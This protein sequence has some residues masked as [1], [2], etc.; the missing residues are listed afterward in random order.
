MSRLYES[1]NC[2]Y[3]RQVIVANATSCRAS[4]IRGQP[5]DRRTQIAEASFA[6][7]DW[8]PVPAGA[9][10]SRQ[11]PGPTR[12]AR[13]KQTSVLTRCKRLGRRLPM[14]C[15]LLQTSQRWCQSLPTPTRPLD[16]S[17]PRQPAR[18]STSSA[19]KYRASPG[20]ACNPSAMS[21]RRRKIAATGIKY[22]TQPLRQ[23]ARTA[24]AKT[25]ADIQTTRA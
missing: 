3:C 17:A 5:S 8:Y 15:P 4:N 23:S 25:D 7:I 10:S 13:R 18:R 24:V 16:E 6:C 1:D 9:G 21:D 2:R 22:A 11:Y 19:G 20:T 14:H 12:T